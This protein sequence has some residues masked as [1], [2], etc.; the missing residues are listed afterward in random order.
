[1]RDG[2]RVSATHHILGTVNLTVPVPV[3]FGKHTRIKRH[4]QDIGYF[5]TASLQLHILH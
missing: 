2:G 4:R 5:G 1:M 3:K